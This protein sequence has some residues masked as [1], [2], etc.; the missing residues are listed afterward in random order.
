M[1][2]VIPESELRRHRSCRAYTSN[3]A[4]DPK[5]KALV[6]VDWDLAV[7]WYLSSPG[8]LEKLEWHIRHG[9]VPMTKEEFA[10]AKSA[11]GE[12]K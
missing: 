6:F 2:V 7:K 10:A 9:L 1:Q 3:P 12:I 11:H 8:G 5:E 4:W